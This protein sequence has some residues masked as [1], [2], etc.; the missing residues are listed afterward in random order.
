[1]KYQQVF[2]VEVTNFDVISILYILPF[3]LIKLTFN[4]M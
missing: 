1:M 3:F 2:Q 4:L